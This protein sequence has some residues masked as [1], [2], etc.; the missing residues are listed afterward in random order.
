MKIKQPLSTSGTLLL[1]VTAALLVQPTLA[2]AQCEPTIVQHP[3]SQTVLEGETVSFTVGWA[4]PTPTMPPVTCYCWYWNALTLPPCPNT[5]VA[6]TDRTATLVLTNVS[7]SYEG[8][9]NAQI[10][11]YGCT[12]L[13]QFGAGGIRSSNALL[14]VF[15]LR[16]DSVAVTGAARDRL[17]L[18]FTALSNRTYTIQCRPAI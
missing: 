7:R 11:N 18:Q 13:C 3:Q 4:D 10:G 6:P 17:A 1:C 8:N 14:L 5:N 16:I 9:Y 12:P 15:P 2:Q